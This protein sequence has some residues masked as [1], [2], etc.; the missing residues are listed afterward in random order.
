M[1]L[2][3]G[4]RRPYVRCPL[5]GVVIENLKKD[6]TH[7]FSICFIIREQCTTPS[8]PEHCMALTLVF[9][10]EVLSSSDR[11]ENL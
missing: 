4:P 3:E 6:L 2:A 10:L 8:I 9:F 7:V 1:V 5:S 11:A